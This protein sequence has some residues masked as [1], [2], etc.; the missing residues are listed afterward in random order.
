[1]VYYQP[2][3]RM[4]RSCQDIRYREMETTQE[5]EGS[6]KL[7]RLLQLLP[8]IHR[9]IQQSGQTTIRHHKER[10]TMEVGRQTAKGLQR[11]PKTTYYL[12]SATTFRPK[13]TNHDR[14]RRIKLCMLWH[15]LST[16][17]RWQMEARS[18]QVQDNVQSRMQLRHP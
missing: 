17:T 6:S 10:D 8:K 5:C 16:G 1:M 7:F 4:S 18:L 9:R 14:N 3:R 13:A 2:R 15:T 11:T 12:T